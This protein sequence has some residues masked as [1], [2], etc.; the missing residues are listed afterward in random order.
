[1]LLLL[2]FIPHFRGSL[3]KF[4]LKFLL[5]LI[6]INPSLFEIACYYFLKFFFHFVDYLFKFLN[7]Q[8]LNL[9]IIFF[10]SYHFK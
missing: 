2:H 10:I 4:H 3:I 1:M 7:F 5:Y 6:L 8:A 9:E